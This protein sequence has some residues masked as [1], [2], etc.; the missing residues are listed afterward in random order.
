MLLSATFWNM[1]RKKL[2]QQLGIEREV[3]EEIVTADK[4]V[5]VKPSKPVKKQVKKN[6]K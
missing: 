3:K 2:R 1:R 4:M 6:D 5:N